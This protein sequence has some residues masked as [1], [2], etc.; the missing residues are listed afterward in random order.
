MYEHPHHRRPP[1]AVT[2]WMAIALVFAL[3]LVGCR[4]KAQPSYD[5]CL[6][7]EAKW[8]PIAAQAACEAAVQADPNSTAGKAAAAKLAALREVAEKERAKKA[9]LEPKPCKAKK[10]VTR[11]IWKG[12]LRPTL[13][14]GET[15]AKCNQDAADLATIEMQCPACVCADDYKDPPGLEL[16]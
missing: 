3:P 5:E 14:E 1:R 16:E 13:L 8:D 12:K 11:C 10:W 4:D 9:A 7:L 6:K 2:P 15:A